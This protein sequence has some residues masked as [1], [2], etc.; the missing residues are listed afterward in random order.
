MSQKNYQD[1]LEGIVK[2]IPNQPGVYQM[3]NEQAEVI[4]VGKAKDLKK[5]VGSYFREKADLDPR[6]KIMVSKVR[7]LNYIVVNSELEALLLETNL[8]KELRPRYNVLMKDD[9]NYVY[10]RVTVNEDFPRISLVRKIFK[11]GAKYYGPKTESYELRESLK[12]LKKLFP[13][14]HCQ[15]DITWDPDLPE[16]V[17]VGN[18]VIKY[19]CLDYHI[20]RCVGP[21]VG[22]VS[23]AEY[24]QLIDRVVDFLNGNYQTLVNELTQEMQELALNKKFEQAALLR[25]KIN[26]ISKTRERQTVSATD[27]DSLDVINLVSQEGQFFVNLFQVRDGR[28]IGQEN[29]IFASLEASEA[30]FAEILEQFLSQYYTVAASFPEQILLPQPISEL[31]VWEDLLLNLASRKVKIVVPSLGRKNSLLDLAQ[32]NAQAYANQMRIKWLTEERFDRKTALTRVRDLLGMSKIPRRIECYDISHLSGTE[33]VGAMVVFENGLSKNKDYRNFQIRSLPATGEEAKPDDFLS[34]AEVL[35]RR[36]KYCLSL[37]KEY[38]LLKSDFGFVLKKAKE[39]VVKLKIEVL[40]D[41]TASLDLEIL[42]K[43]L[44]PKTLMLPLLQKIFGKLKIK[45]YYLKADFEQYFPISFLDLGV[46]LDRTAVDRYVLET[47]KFS[48]VDASLNSVPDLILI[49]GGKGQL[50]AVKKVFKELGVNNIALCSLAKKEEE[51]FLPNR[52]DSLVLAD[53]SPE[54][55]LLTQIRDETHRVAIT[56]NRGKRDKKLSA[57]LLDQVP[58]IGH[59]TKMSLLNKFGSV[60]AV[61]AASEPEL[62]EATNKKIAE[63]IVRLRR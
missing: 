41:A 2:E 11:D 25:D 51:I 54:K 42:A 7:D 53:F 39:E 21:C 13:Y 19:P 9:K 60:D 4:Y 27:G 8:I 20:K 15:L 30:S 6:K 58:G 32:K 26:F 12:F 24:R 28:L 55:F 61:L 17:L 48:F 14:R 3:L 56:H 29:F 59:K 35:R 63:A 45:K 1:L 57:S 37:P 52:P 62:I 47:A 49:D 5:R 23:P 44:D 38:K 50:S 43:K 31:K 18:K 22:V 16:K 40:T 34:M 36:L 33:T 10:V 46:K